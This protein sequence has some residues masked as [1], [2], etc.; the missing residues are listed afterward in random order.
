MAKIYWD[1]SLHPRDRKGRFI[2]KFGII[3]FLDSITGT[4]SYGRAVGSSKSSGKSVITV[5]PVK[6]LKG[7]S[8]PGSKE[9]EI[10]P[11]KVYVA[12]QPKAHLSI[13]APGTQKVGSQAGSNTGGTYTIPSLSKTPDVGKK[14]NAVQAWIKDGKTTGELD[15]ESADKLETLRKAGEFTIGSKVWAYDTD[16]GKALFVR[17]PGAA[18]IRTFKLNDDGSLKLDKYGDPEQDV[19]FTGKKDWTYSEDYTSAELGKVLDANTEEILAELAK[20]HGQPTFTYERPKGVKS[21][22]GLTSNYKSRGLP[23]MTIGSPVKSKFGNKLGASMFGA[24]FYELNA[25]T[26]KWHYINNDGA[27]ESKGYTFEELSAGTNK[28]S[29]VWNPST[30]ATL[31]ASTWHEQQGLLSGDMPTADTSEKFYVK[32]A[33]TAA[34]GKNEA[35]ANAL[36]AEAGV[37]VPEVDYNAEDGN[38][39]SKIIDGEH[40]MPQK[41][42]DQSWLKEVHDD[43]AVDAWLANWDVFGMTY[44]NVLSDAETGAP[45]RIDNGGAL[46]YRAM[47]Q[48]KGADFGSKVGELDQ[49]KAAGKKKAIYNSMTKESELDGAQRVLA[50]DPARIEELVAEHGLPKS[51]ADTLKAR[52]KYIADYYGLPL[53]ETMQPA[54]AEEPT[55]AP[56]LDPLDTAKSKGMSREWT[57]GYDSLFQLSAMAEHGDLIK[58]ASGVHTLGRVAGVENQSINNQLAALMGEGGP[59]HIKKTFEGSRPAHDAM[60]SAL[61]AKSLLNVKWERGDRIELDGKL[62]DVEGVN[63]THGT[64]LVSAPGQT[65]TFPLVLS[66]LEIDSKIKIKR[67]DPPALPDEPAPT[68]SVKTGL[69]ADIEKKVKADLATP[70]PDNGPPVAPAPKKQTDGIGP[71]D[72]TSNVKSMQLGDLTTAAT[73]D[74]VT[75]KVNGAEYIFVKPKGPYAVVTDPNSDDPEKTWL[76]KAST[77]TQPG[78]SPDVKPDA[79]GLPKPASKNGIVPELGMVALAKDGSEGPITMISPDGK[80][81]YIDVGGP[82]PKRK[83]TTAVD[84]VNTDVA[85][86]P[87]PAGIVPAGTPSPG[88]S[89]LSGHD[90]GVYPGGPPALPSTTYVAKED[91]TGSNIVFTTNGQGDIVMEK[92]A[93]QPTASLYAEDGK[94]AVAYEEFPEDTGLPFDVENLP[95]PPDLMGYVLLHQSKQ[96]EHDPAWGAGVVYSQYDDAFVKIPDGEEVVA[97]VTPLENFLSA[98]N[99]LFDGPVSDPQVVDIW[100]SAEDIGEFKTLAELYAE[101]TLLPGTQVS[102]DGK[103]WYEVVGT[104]GLM[105]TVTLSGA[106]N[107]TGDMTMNMDD[108]VT[109]VPYTANAEN[110]EVITPSVSSDPDIVSLPFGEDAV[111]S[112]GTPE[113][114]KSAYDAMSP[115][116]YKTLTESIVGD[117]GSAIY[118]GST[119]KDLNPEGAFFKLTDSATASV[120]NTDTQVWEPHSFEDLPSMNLGSPATP[121]IYPGSA[122]TTYDPETEMFKLNLGSS[123]IEIPKA[124]IEAGEYIWAYSPSVFADGGMN[125]ALFQKKAGS[126]DYLLTLSTGEVSPYP[127]DIEELQNYVHTEKITVPLAADDVDADAD[128]PE[129]GV[130]VQGKTFPEGTKVIHLEK[131]VGAQFSADYV[132]TP[133]ENQWVTLM[134]GME[135]DAMISSEDISALSEKYP[136][137]ELS[138]DVDEL[139]APV[140]SESVIPEATPDATV[141][142]NA[143]LSVYLFSTDE[144]WKHKNFSG[145]HDLNEE[146]AAQLLD[147]GMLTLVQGEPFEVPTP[148]QPKASTKNMTMKGIQPGIGGTHD[149]YLASGDKVSTGAADLINKYGVPAGHEA[150]QFFGNV[151]LLDGHGK[152]YEHDNFGWSESDVS[153]LPSSAKL[154]DVNHLVPKG[155]QQPLKVSAHKTLPLKALMDEISVPEDITHGSILL[156][157]DGA[158]TKYVQVSVSDS[159][160]MSIHS[161]WLMGT[162]NHTLLSE[163]V[164]DTPATHTS[165]SN[166]THVYHPPVVDDPDDVGSIASWKPFE[167]A[168]TVT[169]GSVIKLATTNQIVKISEAD[170]YSVTVSDLWDADKKTWDSQTPFNLSEGSLKSQQASVFS[171]TEAGPQVAP[172]TPAPASETTLSPSGDTHPLVT[173]G[174]FGD[175]KTSVGST[176]LGSVKPGDLVVVENQWGSK[177]AVKATAFTDGVLTSDEFWTPTLADNTWPTESTKLANPI[178]IQVADNATVT[179][180]S[181]TAAAAG[182]TYVPDL[183]E[184]KK[185]VTFTTLNKHVEEGDIVGHN[186]DFYKAIS[187]HAYGSKSGG[188]A[189]SEKWNSDTQQWDTMAAPTT[190]MLSNWYGGT[191]FYYKKAATLGLPTTPEAPISSDALDAAEADL[192]NLAPGVDLPSAA[193]KLAWGG[194]LTK[195]G[196]IPTPGM[197]VLGKGPMSGKILSVNADKT[198]A[199]VLTSEGKKTTRLISALSS[200]KSANYAEKLGPVVPKEIPEGMTLPTDKPADAFKK[201]F[202]NKGAMAALVNGHEGIRNGETSV[203]GVTA[204]SGKKFARVNFTLTKAQRGKLRDFLSSKG[205]EAPTLGA[206]DAQSH[207]AA[208][209]AAGMQLSMRLG[210]EGKWKVDANAPDTQEPTH[211][212]ITVGPWVDGRAIVNLKNIKTGE[213]ITSAFR[214]HS[215]QS[216]AVFTFTSKTWNPD[217]PAPVQPKVAGSFNLSEHAKSMGWTKLSSSDGVTS[218]VKGGVGGELYVEPGDSVSTANSAYAKLTQHVPQNGLRLKNADGTVIEITNVGDDNNSYNGVVTISVPDGG[219]PVAAYSAAMSALGMEHAEHTKESVKAKVRPLLRVLAFGGKDD[220]DTPKSFSDAQL[221]E[222]LAKHTGIPD[223]GWDDVRVGVDES[224]GKVSYFWSDR[225]T[226]ALTQKAPTNLLI[227]AASS[228]NSASAVSTAKTGS[229]NAVFKR[230][231]GMVDAAK[232][233]GIG[234]SPWEDAKN[235]AGH[236]SYTSA[237]SVGAN[238]A[239][240]KSN[241]LASY[242]SAGM[243]VYHRPEAVYGR[244]GDYRLATGDAF[245]AGSSD[246]LQLLVNQSSIR[247]FWV[248]GGLPPESVSMIAMS[249]ASERDKAIKQLK[250]EGVTQIN[251]IPLEDFIVLMSDNK[252]YSDLP[253][254]I[255]PTQTVPLSELP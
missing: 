128:A 153:T 89:G 6:N 85:P 74:K 163:V 105:N 221:F 227:R 1:P 83:S 73:G 47:G 143:M 195:D 156:Q 114:P 171:P 164:V 123:E 80:F 181:K 71:A 249:S 248:G 207:N 240:P 188:L 174:E 176:D 202:E 102:P 87:E 168:A 226:N 111:S 33:K 54:G 91:L 124:E 130:V 84:I 59:F 31:K 209:V 186:G 147:T 99:D 180:Y 38:V 196:Y 40:D 45:V 253:P 177:V 88:E 215:P 140:V 149:L 135:N 113:S 206:W 17:Q 65:D 35:L 187:S 48:P 36:Y 184:F 169:P 66:A 98:E 175:P 109:F 218:A 4:W 158:V 20:L 112:Y 239:L 211:E 13:S 154:I 23:V 212:V 46:L 76:K 194:D 144:G 201:V 235:N 182:P 90:Y 67:W 178:V 172:A 8:K 234:Q 224:I 219:D 92:W 25:D 42:K 14:Y 56:L 121:M 51:L 118:F 237:I 30:G 231:S 68:P 21:P 49:Y 162:Q 170:D 86:A 72:T 32:K 15:S 198:K 29:R 204:P 197:H 200:N 110:I 18:E 179:T 97:F 53:P 152:I 50:I 108:P 12:A 242:K 150:Y 216:G 247:D 5:K 148:A 199:V 222:K 2:R 205:P 78:K 157:E 244:I 10:S 116:A 52:R 131:T 22:Y 191:P 81:V 161:H 241:S 79:A 133:G 166:Y 233:A 134:D 75:S 95:T 39:Y 228:G 213:E 136:G 127:Y 16:K 246:N 146:G 7:D 230:L 26:S 64:M 167:S 24:D 120:F 43:F 223:V 106:G 11:S 173:S 151:F 138:G 137:V 217:K 129:A 220:I 189:F 165:L 141:Y 243:M 94:V 255:N 155:Q 107:W 185:V 160:E 122:P 34:H 82:K 115:Q 57:Q 142:H 251:G 63:R 254:Y 37:Y 104:D 119:L 27:R 61:H 238:S 117:P 145:I 159:G 208:D 58:T 252:K 125:K 192:S 41:M 183:A 69:A 60:F 190:L 28:P 225:V 103:G 126:N 100:P 93:N 19:Y 193:H 236:G 139:A 62:L 44:D 229:A 232:G 250:S 101:G 245:G 9:I 96:Y 203:I 214:S 77:L 210:H 70:L 132:K 55:S 3:K